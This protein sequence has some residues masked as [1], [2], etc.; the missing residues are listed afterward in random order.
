MFPLL[1]IPYYL[2]VGAAG[3]IFISRQTTD[4]NKYKIIGFKSGLTLRKGQNLVETHGLK[5]KKHLPLI[6]GCLC[7]VAT[8]IGAYQSLAQDPMV[9]FIEDDYEGKIQVM[10]TLSLDIKK[11]GQEIPWGVKKIG[12][13]SVWKD[14]GGQG[15]RVGIIDTGIDLSHPDLKENIK[16][17]GWVLDCQNI[18][19]DNGHGSHVAGIIA[20]LD[21]DIGVIG[22]APKVEIYAVKAFS[23]SGRGNI[24]DVIEGL[25][26]CVE[27]K[28]QVINMSFGF[29]NSK[30]LEK[31]IKEVYKRKI[32]LVAASGNSGGDN[33]VMYPARYPEV[34]AVTA[35]NSDDKVAWFSSGGTEV[36]VMAPGAGI[37]STYKNG[38]YKS[39]SGTSMACP[40][41]TAAC[42]LI[43]SKSNLDPN[44]VKEVLLKSCKDMGY[45]KTKQGA[46]LIDVSKA[47]KDA[48]A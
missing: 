12:A 6:N 36:D 31:A 5:V 39:M 48:K 47:V 26:W 33:S 27:N 20:A 43:L 32:V 23:K 10:P 46:G 7:E 37:L 4:T 18:I 3:A 21:N 35:S 14:T 45:S 42:A 29:K 16:M 17:T 15:V 1:L 24:S 44:G 30:A 41:V 40:H 34:I 25:D 19:D 9:E 2:L 28:V 11:Q 13:P 38:G 8:D 22:V